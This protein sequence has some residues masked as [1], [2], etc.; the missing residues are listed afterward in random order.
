MDRI[1]HKMRNTETLWNV[2]PIQTPRSMWLCFMWIHSFDH[3]EFWSLDERL[4]YL[5]IKKFDAKA[6]LTEISVNDMIG[7]KNISM[8]TTETTAELFIDSIYYIFIK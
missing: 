7:L 8:T 6:R 5:L 4:D 2:V 3:P 1:N